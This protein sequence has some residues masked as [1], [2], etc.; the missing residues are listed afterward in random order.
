MF[1]RCVFFSSER[2]F[3]DPGVRDRDRSAQIMITVEL[4]ADAVRQHDRMDLGL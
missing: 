4:A 3:S 1:H 2:H